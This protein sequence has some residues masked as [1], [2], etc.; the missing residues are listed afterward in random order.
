MEI[1]KM[2]KLLNDV[3]MKKIGEYVEGFL[4]ME[5]QMD[6]QSIYSTEGVI[7][8]GRQM[9]D[10]WKKVSGMDMAIQIRIIPTSENIL[11]SVGQGK[12]SDK[13]AAGTIGLFV[14]VPLAIT[15]GIGAFKQN[16]LPEE[17]FNKI[18]NFIMTGGQSATVDLNDVASLKDHEEICPKCKAKNNKT[19]KFCTSCGAALLLIC[20][21]CNTSMA[22]DAKFCSSCGEKAVTDDNSTD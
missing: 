15:A 6:T 7:I 12:W 13:I 21:E 11:V 10:G 5:K 22:N 20:P 19:D 3:S 2:F 18:E 16:K 8:Q 1:S 9:S 4:K 17:I 14:F